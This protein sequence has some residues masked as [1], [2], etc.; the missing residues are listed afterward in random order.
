[1]PEL[2][3][4]YDAKDDIP[5]AVEDFRGLF[6]EKGGKFELTGI[7]GIATP[8]NVSRLEASLKKE[9]EEH[10]GTKDKLGVWGELVHEDVTKS[11]DRIPE[12]EAAADGKLDD[13]KIEELANKRAEGVLKT[14][15]SPLE[16]DIKRLTKERDDL[17][18]ENTGFKAG[19]TRRTIHDSTRKALVAAK[20]IPEA[21]D[22]ALML[23][24][25]IME[26]TEEGAVVT[27]DNVG[28][29]PGLD[30]GSWLTEIQDKRPHWWPGSVGAGARGSGGG[31]G[32]FTGKNP[33]LH[34]SW[35]MTEQGKYLKEH[36]TEKAGRLAAAA[37]TTVGGTK[38]GPKVKAAG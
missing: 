15:L 36:G 3:T 22:D 8:A 9:R 28:V 13:S 21:H 18:E 4:I 37:G 25:R 30:P 38:P 26:I 33:W 24:E 20:V 34:E 12:L 14:K 29:P 10:K 17:L 2:K 31:G 7:S 6:T 19:N 11:L 16:R 32:G 27:R 1:M 5:E 23:A 35:N